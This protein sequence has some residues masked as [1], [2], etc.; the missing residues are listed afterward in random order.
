M[1]GGTGPATPAG[2]VRIFARHADRIAGI[3]LLIVLAVG[4]ASVFSPA[5][6]QSA[7]SVMFEPARR[8]L[9]GLPVYG[10]GAVFSGSRVHA[11]YGPLY[12]LL[13]G[14]AQSVCGLAFWPGRL[15]SAIS[16]AAC[17][18]LLAGLTGGRSRPAFALVAL[19]F[20]LTPGVVAFCSLVRV[21]CLALACVLAAMR[22]MRGRPGARPALAGALC[23]LAMLL[24]SS[25]VAAPAAIGLWL[26]LERRRGAFGFFLGCAVAALAAVAVLAAT[27]LL[28]YYTVNQ[29]L[30]ATTPATFQWF[31]ERC[32]AHFGAP[33]ISI[34]LLAV[35]AGRKRL[36][37]RARLALLWLAM[38]NVVALATVAR[39]G[40]DVNYF[41]EADAALVWLAGMSLRHA[42]AARRDRMRAMLAGAAVLSAV[43]ILPTIVV[44]RAILTSADARGE[45]DA[46]LVR[47]LAALPEGTRVASEFP[48]DTM[49][50]G[51]PVVF[52]DLWMYLQGPASMAASFASAVRAGD[53]D[54]LVVRSCVPIPGFRL[55]SGS[56]ASDPC[57]FVRDGSTVASR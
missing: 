27:G 35:A 54:A 55:V 47:R 43:V 10:R 34:P 52:S 23:V 22:T 46:G 24:K 16:T 28:S 37:R 29:R 25:F 44:H 45:G 5:D 9:A 40:S 15:L 3:G 26:L 56:G 8:I 42:A 6:F 51:Q 57:L 48:R 1:A 14:L 50:A 2:M 7:E 17:V 53:V 41:M 32:L 38:G 49:L 20:L 31:L 36:P 19:V 33:S 11:C 30:L 39:R 12:Y 4:I 13:L 21:D 18:W